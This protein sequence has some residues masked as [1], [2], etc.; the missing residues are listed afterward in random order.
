MGSIAIRPTIAVGNFQV[1][2]EEKF[3]LFSFRC[4]TGFHGNGFMVCSKLFKGQS[5]NV[6]VCERL[7]ERIISL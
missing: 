2:L 4:S 1:R 6:A 3:T 5:K 7:E